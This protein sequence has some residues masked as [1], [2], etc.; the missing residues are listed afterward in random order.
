MADKGFTIDT[1]LKEIG[2][3]LNIPPFALALAKC[4][5]Q[6]PIT[7]RKLPNTGCTLN[8]LFQKLRPTN[9]CPIPF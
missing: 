6:I 1:E 9:C 2:L 4:L 5:F 3:V 8:D 7:L